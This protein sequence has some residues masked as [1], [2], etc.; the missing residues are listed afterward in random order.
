MARVFRVADFRLHVDLWREGW[1]R[2][3][4]YWL[5]EFPHPRYVLQYERMRAHPQWETFR[6]LV[7]LEQNV[8]LRRLWCL[9]KY[10]EELRRDRRP[11][12]P[13]GTHVSLY[14]RET[15][16]KIRDSIEVVAK[17]ANN[18]GYKIKQMYDTF[19]PDF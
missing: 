2:N 7:F 15:T 8:T 17:I 3:V 11:R 10:L 4:K 12:E 18:N 16:D 14:T 1:W 6:M 13:L 19:K 9:T 5:S